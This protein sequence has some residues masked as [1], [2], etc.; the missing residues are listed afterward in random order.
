[1][2]TE[3]GNR[4]AVGRHGV[5]GEVSGDDLREPRPNFWDGPVPPSSQHLLDLPQLCLHP[6]ATRFPPD[7]EVAPPRFLADQHKAEELEGFRLAEPA[8]LAVL[9]RKAAELD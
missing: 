6:I 3:R 5:I 4:P 8:P 1:M 2:I 9:R 7:L